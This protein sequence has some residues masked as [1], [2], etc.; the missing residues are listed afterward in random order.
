MNLT[1]INSYI[2]ILVLKSNINRNLRR[3]YMK[4]DF[5]ELGISSELSE[6]LKKLRIETPTQVQVKSI[7]HILQG[8]DVIAQAQR[9]T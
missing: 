2:L 3:T 4:N 7:P 9:G 6:R 8:K 5:I 1:I